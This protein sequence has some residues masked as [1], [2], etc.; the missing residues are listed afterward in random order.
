MRV[1]LALL[2]VAGL[3]ACSGVHPDHGTS[4]AAAPATQGGFAG[5]QEGSPL[6]SRNLGSGPTTVP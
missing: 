2:L 3:S 5:P 1:V 4:A 6:D